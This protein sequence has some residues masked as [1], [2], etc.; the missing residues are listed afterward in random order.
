M[1]AGGYRSVKVY[2]KVSCLDSADVLCTC[3]HSQGGHPTRQAR[4]RERFLLRSF[5]EENLMT[6]KYDLKKSLR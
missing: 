3:T 4:L 2:Q 5:V 6:T 1:L